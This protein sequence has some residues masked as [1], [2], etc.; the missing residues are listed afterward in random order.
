M[1]K[2]GQLITFDFSTSIILLIM[3][4]III[5]SVIIFSQKLDE[6]KYYEFELEYVFDNFENNLKYADPINNIAFISNYRID[7]DKLKNFANQVTDID[8]YVLGTI[9]NSTDSSHGI[10]LDE[11]AY[12]TCLYFRDE[13]GFI[14]IEGKKALGELKNGDTCHMYFDS[15]DNPCENY[16]QATSFIKPVLLDKHNV[17]ENKIIQMNLVVCKI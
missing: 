13:N 9:S 6:T 12:D 2:K 16:K 11:N 17:A 4:T 8:S 3:F 10:G 1:N 5:V 7:E 15:G 14:E